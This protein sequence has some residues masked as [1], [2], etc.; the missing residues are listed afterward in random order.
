MRS[1]NSLPLLQSVSKPKQANPGLL[2]LRV[3]RRGALMATV[4]LG[5]LAALLLLGGFRGGGGAA[6]GELGCC[7]G[8]ALPPQL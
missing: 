6:T 7:R 4:G 2:G 1:G 5:L 8:I 3:A